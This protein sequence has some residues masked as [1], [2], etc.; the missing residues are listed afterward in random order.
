MRSSLLRRTSL[1]RLV[2]ALVAAG[3]M[4]VSAGVMAGRRVG[5]AAFVVRDSFTLAAAAAFSGLVDPEGPRIQHAA[6]AIELLDGRIAAFWFAGWAEGA[7]DVGIYTASFDG[8][9]WSGCR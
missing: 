8:S 6:S 5:P 2:F 1:S 3:I 7:E 4:A 9:A